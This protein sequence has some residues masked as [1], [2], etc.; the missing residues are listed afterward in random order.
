MKWMAFY[1]MVVAF[2]PMLAEAYVDPGTGSLLFQ[3]AMAS[4]LGIGVYWKRFMKF[5]KSLFSKKSCAN[6]QQKEK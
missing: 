1:L 2:Y 6:D 3:V 4:L 5:L